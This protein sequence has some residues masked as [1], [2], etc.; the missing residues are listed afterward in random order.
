MTLRILQPASATPCHTPLISFLQT[1]FSH[2]GLEAPCTCQVM[3]TCAS[4]LSV[5]RSFMFLLNYGLWPLHMKLQS[6]HTYRFS[7][8]LNWKYF[9]L[10]STYYIVLLHS[11]LSPKLEGKFH[12]RENLSVLFFVLLLYLQCLSHNRYLIFIEQLKKLQNLLSSNI[13][14]V[15]F[16]GH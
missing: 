5:H 11:S 6:V 1:V 12:E 15:L 14:C 4:L 2:T 8:L 13:P 7:I 9:F 16:I 3:P 10:H